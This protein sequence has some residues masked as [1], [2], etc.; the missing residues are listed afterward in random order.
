MKFKKILPIILPTILIISLVALIVLKSAPSKDP[1]KEF[2]E[3]NNYP[4][5]G[6][7]SEDSVTISESDLNTILSQNKNMA[8]YIQDV[9]TKIQADGSLTMKCTLSNVEKLVDSTT[10]LSA[11][12][13]WASAFDGQQMLLKLKIEKNSDNNVQLTPTEITIGEI[14]LDPQIISP[15]IS[16]SIAKSIGN[17]PYNS[18]SIAEGNISFSK[19]LPQFLQQIK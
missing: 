8:S 16:D 12:K 10:G 5:T 3:N 7:F 9:S 15:L 13:T 17:I 1:T 14:T 18:I 2:I 6:Q 11:F 19:N 4:Y